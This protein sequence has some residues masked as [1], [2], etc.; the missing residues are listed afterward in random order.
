MGFEML[1]AHL[2][3]KC[4]RHLAS[5]GVMDANEQDFL[6]HVSAQDHPVSQ[7][8]YHAG[9]GSSP[10][11]ATASL[12]SDFSIKLWSLAVVVQG[13]GS[14]VPLSSTLLCDASEGFLVNEA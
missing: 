8:N 14:A 6:F 11:L 3:K 9:M 5:G 7:A 12:V 4:L 10:H 13:S 1:P 2:V